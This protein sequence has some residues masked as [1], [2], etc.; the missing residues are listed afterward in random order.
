MTHDER[1]KRF[2]QELHELFKSG[3]TA[4]EFAKAVADLARKWKVSA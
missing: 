4:A 3:I 1:K 2:E